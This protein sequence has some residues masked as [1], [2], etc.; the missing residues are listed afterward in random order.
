MRP[1]AAAFLALA[2][3]SL[4]ARA[5]EAPYADGERLTY[6]FF[7][8]VFLVGRGT[9]EARRDKDGSEEFTVV[10]R[11]ND[12]ISALYP[13]EDTLRSRFDP[14]R[15]RSLS[16]EQVR[17]EGPHRVWEQ[18]WFLYDLG[19]GWMH[20]LLTGESKWYEIPREGVLDKLSLVYSMRHKDWRGKDRYSA[21]L[22]NDRGNQA[23]EV[24]KLGTGVVTLD[25]FPPIAAFRVEP[26]PQYMRGFVKRGRMVAWVSDDARKIPLRVVSKL[27][28]GSVSAQL[29]KA[30]GVG[31]WPTGAGAKP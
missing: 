12:F 11:S 29:V 15:Q 4:A 16:W 24:R 9:F 14:G 25:D 1:L 30:E 23:V 18:A 3:C 31:D 22:G 27:P 7:W 6:H 20:S 21:T 5:A 19:H 26:D 2:A 8:G 17:R 10:V 28:V 13:V